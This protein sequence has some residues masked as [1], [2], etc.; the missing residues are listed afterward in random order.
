MAPR[1]PKSDVDESKIREA[2]YQIWEEE[3]RPQGRDYHHWLAA[4]ARMKAI[5]ATKPKA[6]VKLDQDS[7]AAAK[8]KPAAKPAAKA[9]A[10]P[11]AKPKAAPRKKPS[12]S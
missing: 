9:T 10:K 5:N 7:K 4:E 12:A 8:P 6:A 11:A 1:K 2:A 3:G